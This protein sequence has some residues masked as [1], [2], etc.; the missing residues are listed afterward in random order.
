M[1]FVRNQEGEWF[2]SRF[3]WKPRQRSQRAPRNAGNE[4]RASRTP[5]ERYP[6]C[7]TFEV[8]WYE[9]ENAQAIKRVRLKTG[10]GEVVSL[11]T[12]DIFTLN[13]VEMEKL[14]RHLADND[15]KGMRLLEWIVETTLRNPWSDFN[16]RWAR[17]QPQVGREESAQGQGRESTG[18]RGEGSGESDAIRKARELL[19]VEEDA[20][21]KTIR[22]RWRLMMNWAHP[23]KGGSAPLFRM[24]R[25]AGELLLAEKSGGQSGNE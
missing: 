14:R 3:W 7:K 12:R 25:K 1:S 13:D 10:S 2:W 18:S 19:G 16:L 23:D 5:V 11:G 21:E 9:R 17:R 6:N 20:T 22:D 4:R 15:P 24:V 8:Y